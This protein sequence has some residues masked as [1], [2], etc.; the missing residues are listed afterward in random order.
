MPTTPARLAGPRHLHIGAWRA[1]LFALLALLLG[2]AWQA[3]VYGF[4]GLSA[5]PGVPN[6][7]PKL[8]EEIRSAAFTVFRDGSW[9]D[10]FVNGS[11]CTVS[12]IEDMNTGSVFLPNV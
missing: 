11:S 3:L 8:P 9:Y 2:A 4:C 10:V 5:E 12:K 7:N 1:V 6:C